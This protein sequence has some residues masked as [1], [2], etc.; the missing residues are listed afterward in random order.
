MK[1]NF[2]KAV[3][4][5]LA[6]EGGYSNDPHDPGGETNFGICKR[7]HP[8]VDIKNL[9]IDGAK[10]IYRAEYWDPAG[11]DTLPYPMDICVMD[12]FVNPGHWKS[13]MNQYIKMNWQDFLMARIVYYTER[14]IEMEKHYFHGWVNRVLDLWE[15]IKNEDEKAKEV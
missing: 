6:R 14:P 3:A 12:C 9:T 4:F 7:Y 5:V 8:K 1:E 11:C 15:M 10:A 2:D 13:I